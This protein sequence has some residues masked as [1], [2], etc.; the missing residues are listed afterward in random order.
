MNVIQDIQSLNPLLPGTGTHDILLLCLT[1]KSIKTFLL[2][3]GVKKVSPSSSTLVYIHQ[4]YL[5]LTNTVY[6]TKKIIYCPNAVLDHTKHFFLFQQYQKSFWKHV[7]SFRKMDLIGILIHHTLWYHGHHRMSAIQ[8][9]SDNTTSENVKL[10]LASV[11]VRL[12]AICPT[13]EQATMTNI[14]DQAIRLKTRKPPHMYTIDL[15]P[16]HSYH[17]PNPLWF[18]P[19]LDHGYN[20]SIESM[21]QQVWTPM[22]KLLTHWRGGNRFVL[23]IVG[24]FTTHQQYTVTLQ[25]IIRRN[26]YT[27]TLY[28]GILSYMD[29]FEYPI[30]LKV[31]PA[32]SHEVQ[33]YLQLSAINTSE[34]E[35][36]CVPAKH[37]F[38]C[39][40]TPTDQ[41]QLLIMP[42][43]DGSVSDLKQ[44]QPNLPRSFIY[45]VIRHIGTLLQLYAH[46]GLF[47][48]DLKSSN[49]LYRI[50][51]KNVQI[52]LADF[53]SFAMKNEPRSYTYPPPEMLSLDDLDPVAYEQILPFSLGVLFVQLST[54]DPSQ[55]VHLLRH[56]KTR[57]AGIVACRELLWNMYKKPWI[58]DMMSE[59]TN[60]R[61]GM[62][63]IYEELHK[64]QQE[65]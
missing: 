6:G 3:I 65:K 52:F 15:F 59:N 12:Y 49:I 32:S 1:K 36:K 63:T 30:C 4:K 39:D 14:V 9:Y 45:Y 19:E 2:R 42:K 26:T 58:R 34:L 38:V 48:T 13:V 24:V 47:Y 31:L 44:S 28:M 20:V 51:G 41:H 43:M 10:S 23:S 11:I 21:F 27:G 50:A 22:A 62:M 7:A 8:S 57:S 17:Q 25:S 60:K 40:K 35:V 37:I 64:I 56:K 61:T 54:N 53:G 55:N 16:I 29:L 18:V 33:I 46:H 5:Y